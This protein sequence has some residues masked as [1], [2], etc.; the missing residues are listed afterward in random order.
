V[1]DRSV[2]QFLKLGQQT[3]KERRAILERESEQIHDDVFLRLFEQLEHFGCAGR[4]VAI[5]D[6]SQSCFAALNIAQ[7]GTVN[8]P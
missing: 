2:P 6:K 1:D 8:R 7:A 3:V 5:A 4:P